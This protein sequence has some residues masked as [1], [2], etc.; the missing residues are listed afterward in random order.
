MSFS[1]SNPIPPTNAP[2]TYYGTTLVNTAPTASSLQ[3]IDGDMPYWTKPYG[4]LVPGTDSN[5]DQLIVMLGNLYGIANVTQPAAP[6]TGYPA[7][8]LSLDQTIY[9]ATV[10]AA[11]AFSGG[12]A[13]SVGL[14]PALAVD[15]TLNAAQATT[16]LLNYPQGSA[17]PFGGTIRQNQFIL[18]ASSNVVVDN[19]LSG[20]TDYAQRVSSGGS[21]A[22]LANA[23]GGGVE[24][25]KN[26]PG[27]FIFTGGGESFLA[28]VTDA[29]GTFPMISQ[30]VAVQTNA[31][32]APGGTEL[33][34]SFGNFCPNGYQLQREMLSFTRLTSGVIGFLSQLLFA[35]GLDA[36]LTPATQTAVGPASLD[37]MRFN[38][39]PMRWRHRP[40]MVDKSIIPAPMPSIS[41]K[42]F[43][44]FPSW[45]PTS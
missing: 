27:W 20:A 33:T 10:V 31:V 42:Y 13:G 9:T 5:A 7:D 29:V 22:I 3:G 44:S 17:Q 36:L 32:S 34:A 26:Q 6:P 8:A 30:L 4:L 18:I 24:P 1:T 14:L 28:G 41:R 19:Y 25:V 43:F 38:P 45:S 23:Q 39:S 35:G 11:E 16:L 40:P 15:R 21:V 2:G 12:Q 37:F